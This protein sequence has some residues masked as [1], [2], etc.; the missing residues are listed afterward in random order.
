MYIQRIF[1]A[2]ASEKYKDPMLG[3]A[4]QVLDILWPPHILCIYDVVSSKNNPSGPTQQVLFAPLPGDLAC[5]VQALRMF[6]SVRCSSKSTA[7]FFMDCK[8]VAVT[9]S[10]FTMMLRK[11]LTG[12]GIQPSLYSSKS[13]RVGAASICYSLNIHVNISTILETIIYIYL[14]H[15]HTP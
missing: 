8:G 2:K 12:L 6:I 4:A 5:P 14:T 9:A 13:F 11:A 15:R 3:L 1:R 10:R 7:A